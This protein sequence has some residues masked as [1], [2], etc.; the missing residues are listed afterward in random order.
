[1]MLRWLATCA[2]L[3]LTA[4]TPRAGERE[5]IDFPPRV[6]K[7][8]RKVYAHY[9]GCFPIGTKAT[10]H[11]RKNMHDTMDP[12]SKDLV[13]R[14]GGQIRNYPLIPPDMF[15]NLEESADLELRRAVRMG[16]DGFAID[17]WAGGEDAKEFLDVLFK[18]AEEKDYPVELTI[19]C[20]ANCGG[21]GWNTVP[22]VKWLLDRH[23][24]S[25]KLARRDGKPLLFGYQSVWGWHVYLLSQLRKG[26]SEDEVKARMNELRTSPEGWEQVGSAY[27]SFEEQIGRPIYWHFGIGAFFFNV[28]PKMSKDEML[29][30]LPYIARSGIPAI[31]S[32]TNGDVPKGAAEAINKAGAEWCQ[33]IMYQYENIHSRFWYGGPEWL[34][35]VW[36]G[37]IRNSKLLQITTWNDYNE[38][39]VHAPAYN[40]RY[41]IYDLTRHY[42][43]WWKSGAEPTCER[44]RI[45]LFHKKYGP[46]A[47]V[48]PFQA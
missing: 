11:V 23:G 16:L 44:D 20:D 5:T 46:E 12:H 32:F 4:A 15:L 47:R 18:V 21:G 43:Q 26:L 6:Q 38:N 37:A 30:A 40:T 13:K 29:E 36:G 7:L 48:Y 31:G 28:E 34:R 9:M 8:P 42:I 25:P 1:M 33:P 2:I 10:A 3:L 41:T 22:T 19:C 45:Y 39:T 35:G 17:A 27:K 14:Y 24:E